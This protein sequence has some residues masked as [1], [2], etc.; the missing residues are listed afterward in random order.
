MEKGIT[1]D[2]IEQLCKENPVANEQL[3][4]IMAERQVRELQ[5]KVEELDADTEA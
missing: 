2:D 5:A 1:Q 4:R 3:R